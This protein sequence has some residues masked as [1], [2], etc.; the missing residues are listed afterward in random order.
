VVYLLAFDREAVIEALSECPEPVREPFLE[1]IVQVVLKLPPPTSLDLNRLFFVRLNEII[2][3][4]EPADTERWYAVFRVAG[5][6]LRTPRDVA[7]FANALR[8][9]WPSVRGEV[10]LTDLVALTMLQLFDS[11][12]Y[13]AVVKNIEAIAGSGE[14]FL[15]KSKLAA[16]LD[17]DGELQPLSKELIA[18]LFPRLSE[19][20]KIGV[21]DRGDHL[22]NRQQRRVATEEYYR[23]YFIFAGNPD[24]I[25]KSEMDGVLASPQTT[26]QPLI[27]RLI[28]GDGNVRIPEFLAQLMEEVS[29]RPVL[30]G[31]LAS[32]ILDVSDVLVERMDVTRRFFTEDNIAR[33]RRIM[34]FG[35]RSLPPNERD[36]VVTVLET[37]PQ[38]LSVAMDTVN[39]LASEHGLLGRPSDAGGELTVPLEIA[40]RAIDSMR[41]RITALADAGDLLNSPARARMLW[42]WSFLT[43]TEVVKRWLDARLTERESLMKLAA[44][45]PAT[46]Y[47][48]AIKGDGSFL[49]FDKSAYSAIIDVDTLEAALRKLQKSATKPNERETLSRFFGAK[50]G[51]GIDG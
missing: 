32:S 15:E 40:Q 8:V 23:N 14:P 42:S 13:S 21:Y 44:I 10:D 4:E 47:S 1:K 50:R 28:A 29:Q 9:S 46:A 18:H 17:A 26:L 24:R 19:G 37:H 34:L 35:L 48:S 33:L 30:N 2:E 27:A 31:A 49:Y 12:A 5:N 3:D 11:K 20:W 39:L 51:R 41:K 25:S 6:F 36:G 16:R 22:A 7:R 45:L 38:G 43:S